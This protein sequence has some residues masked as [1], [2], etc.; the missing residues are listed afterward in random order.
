MPDAAA[1]APSVAAGAL[2][3]VLALLLAGSLLAVAVARR[4]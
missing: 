1:A 4:R 2:A 3:G